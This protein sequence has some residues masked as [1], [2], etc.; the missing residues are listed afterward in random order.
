MENGKT[1]IIQKRMVLVQL[2]M[3]NHQLVIK[4]LAQKRW[5]IPNMICAEY[6]QDTVNCSFFLKTGVCRY[7]DRC[8]KAHIYPPISNVIVFQNMYDGV[9]MSEVLDEDGDDDLQYDEAEI[10]KHYRDFYF[11]THEEF[12]KFGPLLN[13][14]VK[15]H[16][17][18]SK[19][20]THYAGVQKLCTSS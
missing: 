18:G 19:I 3:L 13:F 17:I 7:G 15:K 12:K 14:K 10:I 1:K 6:L 11:D 9:G 5:V 8:G 4:L 16:M 20:I 2:W